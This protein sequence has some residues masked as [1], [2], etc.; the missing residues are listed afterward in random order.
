[1]SAQSASLQCCESLPVELDN[2]EEPGQGRSW[3]R[4]AGQ[5]GSEHVRS[6][7]AVRY[8]PDSLRRRCCLLEVSSWD[9]PGVRL[10]LPPPGE[11]F[12]LSVL[13]TILAQQPE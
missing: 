7:G 4:S 10:A 11:Q 13:P 5:R 12:E 8:I 2:G 1:M 6:P 9:L 3:T